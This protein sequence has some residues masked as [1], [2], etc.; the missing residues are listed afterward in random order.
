[1]RKYA[2]GTKVPAEQS[3]NEIE[4]TL[5]RFGA[6]QFMYGSMTNA[7]VI[8]FRAHGRHIRFLLPLPAPNGSKESRERELRRRWRSMAMCIKAKLESVATG[9]ETFEESFMA[10]VVLPNGMTVAEHAKPLLEQ[11]HQDGKMPP[12][13]TFGAPT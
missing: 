9:I 11:M 13:L 7:A 8:A 5:T 12:L 2:D 3:R 4:R 6:D 1:M 10:H